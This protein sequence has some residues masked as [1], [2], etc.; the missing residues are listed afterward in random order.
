M[1][2]ALV[3]AAAW[4]FTQAP[5]ALL[6][7][8]E[9]SDALRRRRA[10]RGGRLHS[11]TM[12]RCQECRRIAET[13]AEAQGWRAYIGDDPRDDE[14]PEVAV[15]CPSC[16]AREFGADAPSSRQQPP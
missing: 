13:A 9:L 3:I 15:Y 2:E 10:G 14:P 16:A 4:L 1:I 11:A 8:L 7:W 12:L 6:D 5:R